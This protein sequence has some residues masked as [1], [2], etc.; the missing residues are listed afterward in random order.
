MG[1]GELGIGKLVRVYPAIAIRAAR[2][3]AQFGD[4]VAAVLDDFDVLAI[5]ETEAGTLRAFLGDR[6]GRSA[7]IA[8]LRGRFPDATIEALDVPDENWA[9]R[10]QASLRAVQAGALT[11]APPWDAPEGSARQTIV[12]LPSMG[13]G[14]GHHATTRLCLI[15]LQASDVAGKAVIDI[16]T[17]S[18][19]L[20]L[21][22]ARLGA[23]RVLGIDNDQ[24]A[25][26]N[27]IENR[28]LNALE[29][30]V[31]FRCTDLEAAAGEGTYDVV[32]ANLTGAVLIRFARE[33]SALAAEGGRLILSGLREEEEADVLAAFGRPLM[34]RDTEDGW[35]CVVIRTG[36]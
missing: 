34:A 31:E 19:V 8:A 13:F 20:A 18:G 21:A 9:E 26:D 27:A 29:A 22:A 11:I 1:I 16:G 3:D 23:G 4:L 6:S 24:D 5:D 7:A 10:S 33:L 36:P 32:M 2:A 35:V 17:G 30:H 28:D 15:A 14:T 25:I 12:I